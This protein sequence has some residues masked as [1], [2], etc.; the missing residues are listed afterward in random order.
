MLAISITEKA[1]QQKIIASYFLYNLDNGSMY[2]NYIYYLYIYVLYEHFSLIAQE[3]FEGICF[4]LWMLRLCWF[5]FYLVIASQSVTAE[6]DKQYS[7]INKLAFKA[8]WG[9]GSSICQPQLLS[10]MPV[11]DFIL[12][13]SDEVTAWLQRATSEKK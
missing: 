1:L 6:A 2:I 8:D 4:V 7:A 9:A 12:E 5:V 3:T 13:A 10:V 11:P